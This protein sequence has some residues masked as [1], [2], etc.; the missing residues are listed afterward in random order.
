MSAERMKP[1]LI[2]LG[3]IGLLTF[4]FVQTETNDVKRHHETIFSIQRL[5][6]QDSLLN[7]SILK[8][9]ADRFSN[10]DSISNQKQ[11]IRKLLQWLKSQQLGLYGGRSEEI[12]HAIDEVEEHFLNKMQ[13]IEKFKSHNGILK[14]S[15]YYLPTVIKN[16]QNN[17]LD[18]SY[19]ADMN[20][21]LREILLFNSRPTEQDMTQAKE[22]IEKL[23][24]AERENL[25]EIA[26]HAETIINQRL[27]LQ[28]VVDELFDSP[29]KQSIDRVSQSYSEYNTKNVN[30]A[31]LYRTALFVVALLMLMY[32]LRLFLALRR[33]M[34]NLES[35]LSEVDFQR[36][37]LEDYAIVASI[38]PDR[39]VTYVNDKYVDIS[40]YSREEVVGQTEN[41]LESSIHSESCSREIWDALAAGNRWKGE[42]KKQKKSGNHYWV[43]ATVV[44]FIDK[45][46][47][48]IRYVALL[49][50]ITGRKKSEAEQNSIQRELRLAAT[51]FSD[52][53]MGIV[54]TD[55]SGEI[56]RVNEAFSRLS[57][58]SAREANG[59]ST[60]F[61]WSE[62]DLEDSFDVIWS[63]LVAAGHW[64]GEL[65]Y[66]TKD[67]KDF[68]VWSSV[69]AVL[70]DSGKTSHYINIFNDITDKK[71]VE[72]RIFNLAHFD[73]L[74]KL[75][76]RASFLDSL[77][78]ALPRVSDSRNK[79][80]VLFLDLDNF[81]LINDTMGHA[82]GDELLQVVAAHLRSSVR[83]S[84]IV[85]RLG[86]DE[87][88]IALF[89]IQSF[90]D[91]EKIAEKIM[92]ITKRSV[93][94]GNKKIVI[95]TSIGI[96]MFPDDADNVDSLLKNADMAMY[97]AK[98]D[99]KNSYKIFTEDLAM[100]NIQRHAIEN[101]LRHAI[102]DHQFELFYQPQIVAQTGDIFAVEALIRWHHPEKGIV[103]P[104]RFISVLEDSGLVIEVGKWALMKAC[105]Q[106]IA[107]K[108]LGFDLRMAVNVSAHQLKDDHLLEL[109]KQILGFQKI[110]PHELELE[111]TES[112]L[113]K[114]RERS[115]SVLKAFSNLGISLSLDDFGTGYSS[116][117][118]L[119]K[120]PINTVKIDKSFVS[121]SAGDQQDM[122]FA[123]TILA[124]ADNLNLKV[125]AEG[126]ET[127]EQSEFLRQNGC[128]YLQGYYFS[129]PLPAAQ[130][131]DLLYEH[132]ANDVENAPVRIAR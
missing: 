46:G 77:Q 18:N 52:S 44:P 59:S 21:L 83:K 87:F 42:I 33:T 89:D 119:K 130:L 38:S 31:S 82:S 8:L 20:I 106:L 39:V 132:R 36:K 1:A 56:I 40:E 115:I 70:N 58:F 110:K 104:D 75:P 90:K 103:T 91:V 61:L 72:D 93:T 37:A 76:N 100:E 86:G 10:Y 30:S 69:T 63:K 26:Q 105:S 2:I 131:Q 43:D 49:R 34:H 11:N 14:N 67:G 45:S 60:Q 88:T 65:W 74:T 85:S 118:Y 7:E 15:L 108:A 102:L 99:G 24:R 114:N 35:S 23:N 53:P 6:Y 128:D 54:I 22:F 19:Y 112:S 29:T 120:L 51:V 55:S 121:N 28:S 94:L 97:Q 12:D 111:L 129:K 13:L 109:V 68:P 9:K 79:I 116:L 127:A 96:S 113:L 125:V 107:W 101:D 95:S 78:A 16:T 71:Q 126:V 4:L 32:V 47:S 17:I 92:S 66:R 98:A 81:K 50:D 117:S 84:D 27:K 80:A 25:S 3:L 62:I 5:F 124:M 64:E 41:V 57:G 122:A 48:P 123:T 73:N